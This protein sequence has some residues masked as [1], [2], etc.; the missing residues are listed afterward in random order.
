MR[1]GVGDERSGVRASLVCAGD[2]CHLQ[3]QNLGFRVRG[4]GFG[5]SGSEAGSYL[6]LMNFAY[7]LTLD[8][9]EIKKKK[10][11][12]GFGV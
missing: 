7:H 3:L 8:L 6:R 10:E 12:L 2:F 11:G 9:R 1:C 5:L 4:L